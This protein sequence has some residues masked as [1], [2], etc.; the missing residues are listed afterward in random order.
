M[1]KVLF[2][3]LSN[4][5]DCILTLPVLDALR[6]SMPSASITVLA[7]PRSK[8]VFEGNPAISKVIVFDKRAPF[9]EKAALFFA[10][11]GEHFKVVVD[12]KNSVFGVLIPAK[13]KTYPWVVAPVTL[14]HMKDRHL[15][16]IK[17]IM[18]ALGS[19]DYLHAPRNSLYIS[20]QDEAFIEKT[21][22]E[23]KVPKENKIAIISPGARSD[24]KRWQ[25]TK[26]F[27]VSS[28]LAEEFGFKAALVGDEGDVPVASQLLAQAP[29]EAL[30]NLAGQTTI[31]A[32][33]YLMKRAAIVVTNDSAVLHVAGYLNVPT[34]AVFGITNERKYGPW[35]DSRAVV[36][37][38]IICRPCEEPQCRFKTLECIL[39]ITVRE[40]LTAARNLILGVT[41]EEEEPIRN[42]LIVRTD[43]I[44]DVIL[45][46]PVIKAL[47]ESHPAAHI[48]MMVAPYAKDI[49]DGNPYL[50]E[51]I[52]YDK[53]VR[54]KGWRES[55]AFAR[56]LKVKQFDLAIILHPT[57]R[58]HLITSFANIPRRIGYNYKM[59]Y[60][61]TDPLK[62]TKPLGRKHE[63]EYNLD[64]VRALG[65]E[66][67]DKQLYM[68]IKPDSER[69]VNEAFAHF[70]INPADKL[71]AIHPG[72]SCLS[73]IWPLDRFADVADRLREKY[74]FRVLI[75]GG[76]KDRETTF[77]LCR[78]MKE[79]GIDLG[80]KTSVSQLAS[81]LKRCRLFLSNDSGPVHIASA[82]GTPVIAIF[83]RGQPG[84]SPRRWGPLG[85]KD[86]FLHRETGCL[87]CLAHNCKKGFWC[88]QKI[89]VDDVLKAADDILKVI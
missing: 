89:T 19:S 9:K 33:A 72:A 83:G 85:P 20:P 46:T 49:V 16:K 17:G 26:F 67:K 41:G 2:I 59:G 10:L 51:I 23:H 1:D 29:A 32:L 53:D 56:S 63:L 57:N 30:I 78:A 25:A 42:I 74:G 62:H 52:L 24:T 54:H 34:V 28:L 82:V 3:T 47:R 14:R 86:K 35:S 7:G 22:Q 5:G 8:Q 13:Y 75:V 18:A 79:P 36:K 55:I 61:L 27:N 58:V 37:R 44:G 77:N 43:R 40:V 39:P 76:P 84:L 70:G 60:L 64:V 38:N 69:W 65:I 81:V 11:C 71:L 50:D 4:I 21:L 15:F 80:G 31:G 66:P 48:A 45:S 73:K 88:L 87:V 68:P 12:L 6:E